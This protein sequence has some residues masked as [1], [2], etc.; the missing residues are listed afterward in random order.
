MY[1]IILP[2][3]VAFIATFWFTPKIMKYLSAIGVLGIDQQKKNKPRL[4]SSGGVAVAF[5]IFFGFLSYIAIAT[6]V[7][8]RVDL[9]PMLA[10][11]IAIET[12]TVIGFLDDIAVDRAKSADSSG[13]VEYRRGLKQWQKALMVLPAAIPLMAINAGHT[14]MIFPFIG[15]VE[16]GLL[17]PLLLVPLGVLCVS[18]ATNMLAGINGLE[19]G[20]GSV[21]LAGLGLF[22]LVLGRTEAAVT[23]VVTVAALLAFAYYNWY[24]ARI[25]PGD[26][27]TY[28]IGSVIVSTAIIGNIEK[29]GMVIFAPWII[30]A[31]IKLCHGFRAT[32]LGKLAKDGS[33]KPR[34]DRV[35]SLT[36]VVMRLGNLRED[37]VALVFVAVEAAIVA[38][39][40]GLW[41]LKVI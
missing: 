38:A 31:F 39:T 35:E 23:A 41:L 28:L 12:I 18:N 9:M 40:L 14:T 34:N 8:H 32:S 15:P 24:P 29:F 6:F 37:R 16:F 20:M 25:L 36:H 22:A 30:E 21:A 27:L 10:S 33:L 5:G 19:S 17:Y 1:E 11:M 13:T 2:T 26:S 3:I 4:P 7:L